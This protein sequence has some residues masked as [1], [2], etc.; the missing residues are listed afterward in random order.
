[1]ALNTLTLP[2]PHPLITFSA[3]NVVKRWCFCRECRKCLVNQE[4]YGDKCLFRCHMTS[5]SKVPPPHPTLR[6]TSEACPLPLTARS[7]PEACPPH[8]HWRSL[9]QLSCP[10][11]RLCIA[12]VNHGYQSNILWP[13]SS[14]NKTL[15]ARLLARHKFVTGATLLQLITTIK[16]SKWWFQLYH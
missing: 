3:T 16:L 7:S 6:S 1:V 12:V 14:N 4:A 15:N 13:P 9:P 8:P 10:L 11:P 2:P 5:L